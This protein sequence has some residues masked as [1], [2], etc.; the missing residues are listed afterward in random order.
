MQAMYYFLGSIIFALLAIGV[1][2]IFFMQRKKRKD[3]ERNG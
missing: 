3:Y 1:V 2:V